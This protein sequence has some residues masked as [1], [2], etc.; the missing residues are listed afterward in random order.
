MYI[1]QVKVLV[2]D[3]D[4]VIKGEYNVEEQKE[5]NWFFCSY[6]SY[7]MCM[8]LFENV[9]FENIKVEFKNGVLYVVVFKFKEDFQKKVIDINVQ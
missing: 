9:L 7:N 4:F 5:E 1:L 8:V 6:G 2:E 3:G